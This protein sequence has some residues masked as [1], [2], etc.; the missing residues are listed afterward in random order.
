MR[1]VDRQQLM[2]QG[3]LILREVIPPGQLEPLRASYET[4]VQRKGGDAWLDSGAQPRL[5]TSELIDASTANAVEIWLGESTLGVARQLLAMPEPAVTDMWAM[6]SPLRDHGPANW[7]RDLHMLDMAPLRVLQDSLIENGPVYVQWNI[8]L[9]DDDV[10]WVVPGS[11]RRLNTDAE[12]RSLGNDDRVPVPGGVPV[13]LKAGD[14][15]AYMIPILHSVRMLDGQ[16][17]HLTTHPVPTK[18]KCHFLHDHV[19][20]GKHSP[21]CLA[22]VQYDLPR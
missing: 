8:P 13:D 6:C 22:H 20:R 14:G 18:M 4:L 10:L 1:Q 17:H 15:V 21:I 16:L 19:H 12:K 2:D 3:Y 7:H 9:Y 5:S 11:H